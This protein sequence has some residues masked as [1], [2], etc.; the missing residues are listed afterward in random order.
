[1]FAILNMWNYK[2]D[3]ARRHVDDMKDDS[4]T[5]VQ[6]ILSLCCVLV[7]VY[8]FLF[9]DSS[10]RVMAARAPSSYFPP[11]MPKDSS[12]TFNSYHTLMLQ[13]YRNSPITLKVNTPT[14]IMLS[15]A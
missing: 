11:C 3:E 14:A 6:V 12:R 7:H 8:A 5:M 9:F 4:N 1:M 15:I 10:S 2:R 13:Q